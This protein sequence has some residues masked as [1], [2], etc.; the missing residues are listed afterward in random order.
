[1]RIRLSLTLEITRSPRRA[2]LP[3]PA[4]TFESQGALLEQIGQRRFVGFR[5]EE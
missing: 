1:M 2:E 5:P 3:A 4:E